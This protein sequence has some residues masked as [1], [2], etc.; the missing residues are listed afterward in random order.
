M[1]GEP[2][3]QQHQI[4]GHDRDGA[5]GDF[6]VEGELGAGED[7]GA[8]A[9][10]MGEEGGHVVGGLV[11]RRRTEGAFAP[12]TI[13]LMQTFAAQSVLAIENAR[14]I[15][16]ARHAQAASD[17]ALTDLRRVQDRLVQTEKMA[18]LG[19]LAAGIAHEI[20]SPL[21]FANNF[22]EL[23]AELVV[24]LQEV[25]A[26]AQIGAMLR[27]EVDDIT[28]LLKGNLEKVVSHGKRADGIVK[29]MLLHSRESGGEMREVDLNTSIRRPILTTRVVASLR[30]HLLPPTSPPPSS[31]PTPP[32]GRTSPP[33]PPP[34]PAASSTM[35]SS[36]HPTMTTIPRPSNSSA[37]SQPSFNGRYSPLRHWRPPQRPPTSSAASH[38][39]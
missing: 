31:R 39:R 36:P 13:A 8:L 37:T 33:K 4:A 18:S 9:A 17:A 2:F 1:E 14:L 22:S 28:T 34:P 21:T 7:V 15:E 26:P 38:V 32:L 23:S 5:P 29:N 35:S 27:T 12:A 11:I 19:Q 3:R 30:R 25:L 16:A 20:Q 6:A 10:A 24:E